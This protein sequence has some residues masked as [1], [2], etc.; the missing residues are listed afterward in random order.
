MT[1]I[2]ASRHT[3]HRNGVAMPFLRGIQF[4]RPR[5]LRT[6]LPA[7]TLQPGGA[8]G[9]WQEMFLITAGR[10]KSIHVDVSAIELTAVYGTVPATGRPQAARDRLATEE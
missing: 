5:A 3:H 7:I 8:T 10:H 9:I 2:V 4:I 1:T 6:W